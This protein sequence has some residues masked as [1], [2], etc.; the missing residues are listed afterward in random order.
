MLLL[1]KLALTIP[2]IFIGLC[3]GGYLYNLAT[4]APRQGVSAG[5]QA[6]LVRDAQRYTTDY[7]L[8][9]GVTMIAAA[10]CCASLIWL[11][12]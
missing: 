5:D 7:D 11:L 9:E 10:I 1:I 6:R 12:L 4:A 2:A 8:A 3:T